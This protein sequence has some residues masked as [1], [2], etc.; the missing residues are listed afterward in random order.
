MAIAGFSAL[1]IAA[2]IFLPGDRAAGVLSPAPTA[3]AAE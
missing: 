1:I 2:A 3:S